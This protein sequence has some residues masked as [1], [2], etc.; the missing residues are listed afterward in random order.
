M[1]E[2]LPTN[3]TQYEQELE[4]TI[5]RASSLEVQTDLLW[6]PA[7]CPEPFLPWLAWAFAVDAW[8]SNWSAEIKRQFISNSVFVHK[9][10]GTRAALRRV[11]NNL[12]ANVEI[13]EWFETDSEP[14]TFNLTAFANANMVN[15]GEPILN[16]T[17]YRNLR[18]VVDSVKPVRSH[19][20]FN[21]GV[22]FETPLVFTF[23]AV[24]I[25][26]TRSQATPIVDTTVTAPV[27]I[28]FTATIIAVTRIT[29]TP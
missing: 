21:V 14:H 10:K 29:A 28:S 7:F 8:D 13:Q 11:L 18:R 27:S 6:N 17:L 3:A 2:L 23:S 9:Q 22:N 5:R 24:S 16:A 20:D 19:Y 4:R 15:E 25:T 12:G 26:T 1:S